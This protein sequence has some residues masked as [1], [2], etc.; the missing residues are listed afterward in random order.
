[1]PNVYFNKLFLWGFYLVSLG[2]ILFFVHSSVRITL[3]TLFLKNNL[4]CRNRYTLQWFFIFPEH[5]SSRNFQ[6]YCANLKYDLQIFILIWFKAQGI[7]SISSDGSVSDTIT[8]LHI[9]TGWN[10]KAF[11]HCVAVLGNISRNT[12]RKGIQYPSKAAV[13]LKCSTSKGVQVGHEHYLHLISLWV[14]RYFIYQKSFPLHCQNFA[15]LLSGIYWP[16][17]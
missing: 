8:L 15:Q 7:A 5:P 6:K 3:Y 10:R 12:H 16:K 1:M 13:Q 17:E 4:S 11:Q 2:F 14:L 9:K